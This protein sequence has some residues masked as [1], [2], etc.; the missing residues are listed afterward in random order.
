[1]PATWIVSLTLATSKHYR[2]GGEVRRRV[3][4]GVA[5]RLQVGLGSGRVDQLE[6][7]L[8]AECSRREANELDQLGAQLRGGREAL[9]VGM[10]ELAPRA[11]ASGRPAVLCVVGAAPVGE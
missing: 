3:L 11:E 9:T 7:R 8:A 1:M 2:A 4:R 6:L 10:Q 5:S